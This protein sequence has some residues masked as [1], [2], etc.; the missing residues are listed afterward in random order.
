MSPALDGRAFSG[1]ADRHDI[2][3][4]RF[5]SQSLDKILALSYHLSQMRQRGLSNPGDTRRK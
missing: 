3:P 5:L 4:L 1:P 2:Q